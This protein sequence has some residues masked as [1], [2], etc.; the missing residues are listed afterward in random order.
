MKK[1]LLVTGVLVILALAV[2]GWAI[3]AG[4]KGVQYRMEKVSRGDIVSV[5]TAS[6]TINPV[7]T[8]QVGTQVSGTISTLY[9]DFNS[10]VR[11][12]QLLARI[13]PATAQA[14]TDQARANLAVAN[15]NVTKA[16]AVLLDAE[17]T[18]K[19]DQE[20]IAGD[21]IAR[22]ELDVAE[23][24]HSQ[25]Q[26]SLNAV[27]AQVGQAQAALR[28]A[29]TNLGYTSIISPVNGIVISRNVDVGQTVAASFT[30]PTL[31]SIAQDVTKMQVDVTVDEA[32]IARIQVG[33]DTEFTVDAYPDEPFRGQVTQVRNA[34][35]TVQ[36]VVT[37]DVIVTVAN[38]DLKLK[39]GMSANISFVVDRRNNV[40]RIPEI[41][42]R[43]KLPGASAGK[44][45]DMKGGIGVWILENGKP[46]RVEVKTGPS[47]GTYT[48]L[49]SGQLQEGQDLITDMQQGSKKATTNSVP[50]FRP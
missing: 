24:N 50:M 49:V 39:P 46:M 25:A 31:F 20:L 17:R 48:E 32:D 1:K 33:Q 19:R 26:A 41:A 47:N 10:R 9:V 11:K 27:K 23:T 28:V 4:K 36:N 16:E 38:P 44:R 43:F 40:L 37:Y 12:G 34:P 15:A 13:D 30:T 42:L 35:T 5:V 29:E 22:S 18:Y 2:A 6:G 45:V 21:F 14:Q 7:T 8:V 3:K